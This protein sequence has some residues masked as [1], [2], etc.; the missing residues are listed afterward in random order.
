MTELSELKHLNVKSCNYVDRSS[1]PNAYAR[2]LD[3]NAS[4]GVLKQIT[5][6]VIKLNLFT[7]MFILKF[8]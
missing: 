6:F 5:L 7:S 2:D 3:V 1:P 4:L 8:Y